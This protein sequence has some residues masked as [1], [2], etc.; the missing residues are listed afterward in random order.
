LA[1]LRLARRA[2][3]DI[4]ELLGWSESRFGLDARARYGALIE[5]A[6]RDVARDPLRPGSHPRPELGLDLRSYHLRHSRS[7]AKRRG[8]GVGEPRHV[9]YY[10]VVSPELVRV[11]RV[12]HDA[13][14]VKRHMSE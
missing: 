11:E 9:I 12:L 13:M 8:G 14:D 2:D 7:R 3:A 6:L 5:T 4:D 10:R 1:E